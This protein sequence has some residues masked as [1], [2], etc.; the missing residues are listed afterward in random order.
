[1]PRYLA[2]AALELGRWAIALAAARALTGRMPGP[3]PALMQA[4]ALDGMGRQADGVAILAALPPPDTAAEERQLFQGWT[5]EL[6]KTVIEL[7]QGDTPPGGKKSAPI[8]VVFFDRH[9][10]RVMLEALARK[11]HAA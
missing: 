2:A 11:R 5:K 8:H 3:R 6:L 4:F 7:A 10:Q 1:M 9:E